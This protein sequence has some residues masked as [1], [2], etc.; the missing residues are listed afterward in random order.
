MFIN[1]TKNLSRILRD[2]RLQKKLSQ[3]EAAQIVGIK[4]TTVSKIEIN[5]EKTQLKTFFR[6]I[7][8]LDL[9]LHLLPKKPPC[10]TDK[11]SETDGSETKEW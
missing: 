10:N 6:I 3:S 1:N 7:S 5:P 4:Q 11:E 8:A 2:F 9:E